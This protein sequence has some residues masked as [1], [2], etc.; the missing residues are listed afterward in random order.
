MH[1]FG[2]PRDGRDRAPGARPTWRTRT[3]PCRRSVWTW[4]WSAPLGRVRRACTPT[5]G[6][7][8][9]PGT[10]ARCC[11]ASRTWSPRTRW[12]R[13]ARGRPSSS[14]AGTGV[15]SWVGADRLRGRRRRDRGERTGCARDVLDGL[16]G[17]RPGPGARRAQRH[18]H[19]RSTGP[20]RSATPSARPASTR[21]GRTSCSSGGSPGR[22]AS[23]TSSRPRT[24]STRR[25]RSCS[26]PARRTPRRS[27]RRPSGAVAALSAAR[28]GVVW[29]RRMLP[30]DRGPP[31]AVGRDRVRL[32]VGLRAAGDREPGG[33]GVRDGRRRLGRRRHPG[34]RRRTARPGC[35][36]TT[37]PRTPGGFERDLAD[38]VNALVADPGRAARDGRGAA[39]SAR[40]A[41]SPGRRWPA[42]P[43]EVYRPRS[44]LRADGT[45]RRSVP[46]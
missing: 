16:P 46:S 18:R 3:P 33:D 4:R 37:T 7:P 25:R 41:S 43:L 38:A 1:C 14:A 12:S 29:I 22:R 26:A 6:T 5:P 19:R 35:W 32:P 36:S 30:S 45:P 42:G 13:C 23:G 21:T 9:W 8:T 20:T 34:G 11:T 40:C 2:A 39:G 10:S 44:D 27:P 17:G 28:G 31:A 15:S 24:T